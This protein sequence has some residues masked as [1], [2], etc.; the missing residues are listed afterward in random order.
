MF[1]FI[2]LGLHS[3]NNQHQI[4][5]L[6]DCITVLYMFHRRPVSDNEFVINTRGWTQRLVLP[7]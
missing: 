4:N 1:P 2:A 5:R 3:P 6:R 7:L